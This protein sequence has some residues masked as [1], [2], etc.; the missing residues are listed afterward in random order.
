VSE[1]HSHPEKCKGGTN[2]TQKEN[3]GVWGAHKLKSTSEGQEGMQ[4]SKEHSQTGKHRG[5]DK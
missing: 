2:Q 3:F 4:V 5:Q 1:G